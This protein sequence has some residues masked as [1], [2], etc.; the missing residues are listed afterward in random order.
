M[1]DGVGGSNL[2]GAAAIGGGGGE[3]AAAGAHAQGDGAE[4]VG[5]LGPAAHGPVLGLVQA[6]EDGPFGRGHAGLGAR[7]RVG[8]AR[9]LL[10]AVL[11]LAQGRGVQR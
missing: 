2:A 3:D 9:A 6:Q 8:E 5:A 7:L 4:R 11:E 10:G 1:S